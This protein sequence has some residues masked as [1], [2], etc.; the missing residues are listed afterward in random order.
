[1]NARY[2][3]FWL[4]SNDV[5][6]Q[7]EVLAAG[8]TNQIEWTAQLAAA[9][10]V[11]VPPMAEQHRIVAKVDELMALCDALERESAG[12][13]AAHQALVEILLAT[14]LNS[15]DATNLAR[16]WA[17]LEIH[18][19]TLFTTD[20]SIDAL[21]QT[22]L[23][24]AVRGKLVEQN[25]GDEAAIKLVGKIAEM[26]QALV[27]LREAKNLKTGKKIVERE[28]D[29][30]IPDKWEWVR[31]EHIALIGTGSTPSRDR[32]D[33]YYPAEFNWVTSGETSK[34]FI[35]HTAE[36]ISGKA[37]KE[38]NVSICPAGTLIVAMYGQGKTRGQI[39]ELLVEAGTNQA[40]AT[41]QMVEKSNHHRRYIKLFFQMAYAAIRRKSAGGAQPNLNVGKIA[42]LPIPV[43]P[44]AEQHRIVAKVDALMALCDALKARLDDAAQT[45]RHLADAITQHAAA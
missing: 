1:M 29:F 10:V 39:S 7:I 25:Q 43:P 15:A 37:L 11:P 35:E 36:K 38:T 3:Q 26:R 22:I 44:L 4:A 28:L 14:L 30:Q 33:Y 34:D 24:L 6:G 16:D 45:Q 32:K 8:S 31:L 9:Q 12:T 2:L 19:D 5:Y 18:F 20:A 21:K 40:C 23:D 17:R 13:M 41:I 42:E 27:T